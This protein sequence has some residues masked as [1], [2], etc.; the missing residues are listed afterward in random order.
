MKIVV[1][2]KDFPDPPERPRSN[3][4]ETHKPSGYQDADLGMS[5]DE[6]T[7]DLAE[8][9][10]YRTPV[11][12]L[13]VTHV[14]PKSRAAKQGLCAGMVVLRVDNELVRNL[15]DYRQLTATRSLEG[16]VLMLVGTP[17]RRHFTVL[18]P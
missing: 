7:P 12:G 17:Q 1:R 9:L 8:D 18:R 15:E 6:L 2:P 10:G 3:D 16:G 11:E 14:Q 4:T 13:V 5:L